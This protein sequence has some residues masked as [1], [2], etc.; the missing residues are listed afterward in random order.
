MKALIDGDILRYEIGFAAEAAIRATTQDPDALPSWDYV[1][2]CLLRRVEEIETK[3]EADVPSVI[4]ITEGPTFREQVA[5]KK[6]YKGTRIAKKPWH[7]SN[8]TTYMNYHMNTFVCHGLEADDFM[9]MDHLKDPDTVICSRDKDLRQVPGW[10]YSWELGY[11]AEF[12]PVNIDQIGYLHLSDK[13]K[14]SGTGLK[15]FHAQCLMGDT[16]DNIPGLPG[17]GPV[18]AYEVLK[19]LDDPEEMQEAVC[20]EYRK[21]YG[22]DYEHELLEQGRLLWMTRRMT[23][24]NTPELWEIGMAE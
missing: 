19:M 7:F 10:L 21:H 8:I 17:C 14:L 11:Q 5:R 4:Y 18:R 6:E 1:E 16:V 15:F 3:V 13:N 22:N 24:E 9:T 12:G 23:P 2:A 20:D